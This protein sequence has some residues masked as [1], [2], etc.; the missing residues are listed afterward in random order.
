M[1]NSRSFLCLFKPKVR[2]YPFFKYVLEQ[3][4]CNVSQKQ[5]VKC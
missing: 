2:D 4:L 1:W 3:N 5:K